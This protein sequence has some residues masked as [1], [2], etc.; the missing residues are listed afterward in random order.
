MDENTTPAE[1]TITD[2]S[3][4]SEVLE[5]GLTIVRETLDHLYRAGLL[6]GYAAVLDPDPEVSPEMGTM[7]VSCCVGHAAQCLHP[8]LVDTSGD[9]SLRAASAAVA[10]RELLDMFR[11]SFPTMPEAGPQERR[12]DAEDE[13]KEADAE[14]AYATLRSVTGK[15]LRNFPGSGTDDPE[16]ARWE[17]ENGIGTACRKCDELIGTGTFHT[18]PCEPYEGARGGYYDPTGEMGNGYE[19]GTGLYL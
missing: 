13:I 3:T 16:D 11:G 18:G 17:A 7:L 9:E 6:S 4:P 14:A 2:E 8:R 15:A 1:V 19:E 10:A 12:T 5:A